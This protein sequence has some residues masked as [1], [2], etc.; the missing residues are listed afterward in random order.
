MLETGQWVGK[1]VFDKS[2]DGTA[3]D[4]IHEGF[5]QNRRTSSQGGHI[6]I[7]HDQD[8][9]FEPWAKVSIASWKSY[10][11]KRK[12][13][14]TLA[15]ECQALVS[16]VGNLHWHR[17]LFSEAQNSP[18]Q[19]RDWEK[20]LE[21][22]PFL[23]VTDSKSL[24]DTVSKQ[25]CPFSQVDDKRTAID[26]S[27]LKH[28][29]EGAGT[30]RWI[31]GR[32][33]ISDNLTKNSGGNYLRFVM[34]RGQWT[35]N[36]QGFTELSKYRTAQAIGLKEQLD[37]GAR[38]FDLRLVKTGGEIHFH[39][40]ETA[41][42]NWVS[43]QPL[44]G[45]LPLLV[46]WAGEHPSQFVIF[47]VGHCAKKGWIEY[48]SKPCSDAEFVKPFTAQ[49]VAFETKCDKLRNMTLA[50]AM[51]ASTLRNGG[52]LLAIDLDCVETNW[53]SEV[54]KAEQVQPYVAE[55]MKQMQG[56][57]KLFQIQALMQQKFL[58]QRSYQ[59]N[60][61]VASW[62]TDTHLLDGVN[63]LEINT[64]CAYGMAISRSL[65][66]TISSTDADSCMQI[67]KKKCPA[68]DNERPRE[69]QDAE[70]WLV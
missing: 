28:D 51:K 29:L 16:G 4:K 66:A 15:A 3:A 47:V 13:V 68:C 59:L 6:I 56:S 54:T 14:N 24:Y 31:D 41:I 67:C 69:K 17:F 61:E 48:T 8:L 2:Q 50:Q 63:F 46:E 32:N 27:I 30:V 1:T 12:V 70:G 23:A 5:L 49:G 33:M 9:Q 35:L 62:I 26:V 34:S 43:S 55:T 57:G 11:L 19:D 37:C 40:G 36:E 7:Y 22:L 42:L 20:R 53:K 52:H 10:T 25:T 21:K 38:S 64:I 18:D 45:E 60:K 58:I 44:S 65:G 39:H